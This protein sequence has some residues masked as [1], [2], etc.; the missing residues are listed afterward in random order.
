MWPGRAP[1]KEPACLSDHLIGADKHGW[2][3]RQSKR[4]GS[5]VVDDQLDLG[6]KFNRQVAGVRPFQNFA[7][8]GR[9]AMKIFIQVDAIADQAARIDMAAKAV[10]GSRTSAASA[11]TRSRSWKHN[12]STSTMIASTCSSAMAWN[13][14]SRSAGA[15]TS[16]G[17]AVIP[18]LRH[19][20]SSS[21]RSMMM[22]LATFTI[23]PSLARPG[24]SCSA[25]ST[26]L[27]TRPSMRNNTP[28]TL[29]P[30]GPDLQS[31]QSRLD[32][33]AGDR[34]SVSS[35]STPSSRRLWE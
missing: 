31:S 32:R 6:R 28:V 5:R 16:A 13:A 35:G 18:N 24:I 29:P 7:D 20:S 15:R 34:R 30:G 4:L 2:R 17:R 25:S 3:D 14:R 1:C 26:C 9:A 33:R 10:D 8:I 19:V 27:L 12:P 23:N 11:A 22:P 21:C